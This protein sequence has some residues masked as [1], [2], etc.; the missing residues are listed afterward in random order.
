MSLTPLASNRCFALF[1]SDALRPGV[2]SAAA[3]KKINLCTAA[4]IPHH[5]LKRRAIENY[6]PCPKLKQWAYKEPTRHLEMQKRQRRVLP[7]VNLSEAQRHHFNLKRGFLGDARH[8]DRTPEVDVLYATL[9]TAVRS[10]LDE[11]IDPGIA[12]DTFGEGIVEDWLIS[13]NQTAETN[14]FVSKILEVL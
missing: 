5:C 8:A 14:A 13:D 12:P 11:G 4:N 6:I 2:I 9:A 3:N 7:F 10:A 1:D